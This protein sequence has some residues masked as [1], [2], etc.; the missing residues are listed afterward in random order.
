MTD[1]SNLDN[2]AAA[3]QSSSAKIKAYAQ[4][5]AAATQSQEVDIQKALA[6]QAQI[7]ALDARLDALENPNPPPPSG[8]GG[9]LPPRLSESTG[10]TFYVATTGSDSAVGSQASPWKTIGKA[11]VALTAGQKA[12]IAPGNYTE[13]VSVTRNLSGPQPAT[14]E[15]LD[16]ANKPVIVGSIRPQNSGTAVAA[17]WRFRNLKVD[18]AN[19]GINYAVKITNDGSANVPH[20]LEFYGCEI[21]GVNSGSGQP[22]GML[23]QAGVGSTVPYRIH[24]YNCLVHNIQNT[25]YSANQIHSFYLKT[26]EALVFANNVSRDEPGFDFHVYGGTTSTQG[27]RNSFI[28][29]NTCVRSSARG[30]VLVMCDSSGTPANYLHGGNRIYNNIVVD[31]ATSPYWSQFESV[32]NG[33]ASPLNLWDANLAFGFGGNISTNAVGTDASSTFVHQPVNADPKFVNKAANDFHLQAGSPAIGTGLPDYTPPF[34]FYGN[35]RVSADLGA[36]GS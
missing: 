23:I 1:V 3:I 21:Y 14:I 13:N 22:Q 16:P 2:L 34:D 32:V 19:S 28:V 18:G 10:Q 6:L 27:V 4:A 30:G 26:G 29:N 9:S 25:A 5:Q 11:V 12:L 35:A 17:F 33:P 31:A 7:D 20:D 24:V 15:A 8:L 36:F